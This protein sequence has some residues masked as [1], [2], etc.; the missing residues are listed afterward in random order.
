MEQGA[1][2]GRAAA[3]QQGQGLPAAAGEPG[4]QQRQQL[5]PARVDP[6]NPLGLTPEL[7]R[8]GVDVLDPRLRFLRRA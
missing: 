6:G 7:L 3:G 1:D 4:E 2:A 5:Q 8:H